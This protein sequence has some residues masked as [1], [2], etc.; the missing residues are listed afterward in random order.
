MPRRKKQPDRRNP[1]EPS[2]WTDMCAAIARGENVNEKLAAIG[3][4]ERPKSAKA[5]RAIAEAMDVHRAALEAAKRAVAAWA[6]KHEGSR[7]EVASGMIWLLNEC[8]NDKTGDKTLVTV[9][10]LFSEHV[11]L[12]HAD[13]ANAV[14][15]ALGQLGVAA[16]ALG[17]RRSMRLVKEDR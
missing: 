12:L 9:D 16:Q 7:D 8:V 6:T 5:D 17:H 4:G 10:E 13:R 14:A 11:E 15:H 2:A 1:A 3:R